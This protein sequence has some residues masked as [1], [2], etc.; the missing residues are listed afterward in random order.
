MS[1]RIAELKRKLESDPET[2]TLPLYLS[3]LRRQNLLELEQFHTKKFTS[4]DNNWRLYYNNREIP[5]CLETKDLFKY[6]IEKLQVSKHKELRIIACWNLLEKCFKRSKDIGRFFS[7]FLNDPDI[8]D[9]ARHYIKFEECDPKMRQRII[10]CFRNGHLDIDILQAIDRSKITELIPDLIISYKVP[11]NILYRSEI[12]DLIIRLGNESFIDVILE[13]FRNNPS[14]ITPTLIHLVGQNAP[15]K[16]WEDFREILESPYLQNREGIKSSAILAIGAE[17]SDR[18]ISI[19]KD[20]ENDRSLHVAS[21]AQY[22]LSQNLHLDKKDKQKY[23][24]GSFAKRV[25][26]SQFRTQVYY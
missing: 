26:E 4:G 3:E 6:V 11:K 16:G 20:F 24:D 21:A 12:A 2:D 7:K 14:G 1:D 9:V 18:I 17:K 13:E 22:A 19:L 5:V 23:G 10:D 15:K 8:G 25:L